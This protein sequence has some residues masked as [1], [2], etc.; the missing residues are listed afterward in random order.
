MLFLAQPT[1]SQNGQAFTESTKMAFKNPR[2]VKIMFK[3]V[4]VGSRTDV[5]KERD[6][7]VR[8]SD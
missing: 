2:H 5:L 3:T 1:I 6:P 7:G 4:L 8:S